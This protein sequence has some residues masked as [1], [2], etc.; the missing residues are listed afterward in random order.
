[1]GGV[2][3]RLDEIMQVCP[4]E[5]DRESGWREGMSEDLEPED[6]IPKPYKGDSAEMYREMSLD[7]TSD[8]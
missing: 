5:G 8:L 3:S 2:R 4:E 6:K 7:M 1:M